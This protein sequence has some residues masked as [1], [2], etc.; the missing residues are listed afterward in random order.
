MPLHSMLL[1]VSTSVLGSLTEVRGGKSAY[2]DT[3]GRGCQQSRHR[4]CLILLHG[5]VARAQMSNCPHHHFPLQHHEWPTGA[6][7]SSMHMAPGIFL[8]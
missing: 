1:L 2:F 6:D 4:R 7:V 5:R 3:L 8:L